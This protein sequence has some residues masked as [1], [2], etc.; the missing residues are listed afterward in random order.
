VTQSAAPHPELAEPTIDGLRARLDSGE[1]TAVRLAEMHLE[2]IE[3]LDRRG[4]ALR[5]VIELNPEAIDIA[6]RLD[7]ERRDG[8]VRRLLHGIPVL[9]KDNI[10]TRDRM[11]TTAGSLALAAAPAP[12][13]AALVARLREAGMVLLGKTNL[14]EWANFRSSRSASGWSARGRQTRNAYVL[15]RS[16]SGSSSGSAV[17]VAAGLAPVAIGT[18]TDGSIISPS[19]ANGL[20]GFKPTVGRISTSGIVPI[21]ASQD[22]AGPQA[23]RVADALAL[24]GGLVGG[25]APIELDGSALKGRRIGILGEPF[26]GYSEHADRVFA[27][28]LAALRDA[29]AELV[30]VEVPAFAELARSEAELTILLHEFK[31]G[32]NAYLADRRGVAV[33]SLEDVIA[34]NLEHEAEEMPYFRQERFEQAQ[35]TESLH[36]ERYIEALTTARR[37]ARTEGIDL[38]M[39][40][41]N[42]NAVA[43]PSTGPAW[44]VDRISGDRYL[45]DA[46]GP[47]AVAGYPH[48]TVPAGLALDALPVGLSLFGRPDDEAAL[49]AMAYAFERTTQAR[50]SPRFL[51]TL[52]LP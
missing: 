21:S 30:A 49:F 10:D 13:D 27:E 23:R 28:A 39:A 4:P 43:A 1:L 32:L 22:T 35:A 33:H 17:A 16:P 20:V 9:V 41:H 11:L 46:C 25:Q 5:S 14:S 12:A 15:D 42:L 3:A 38:V 19:S 52:E 31:A 26:T 47:A 40:Q 29:G 6:E 36:A 50:R 8:R 2:R 24:Y 7:R 34:F 37:L 51:P 18:E 45:G 48:I 44:V